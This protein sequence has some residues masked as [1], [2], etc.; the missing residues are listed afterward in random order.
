MSK[1][2]KSRKIQLKNTDEN[3]GVGISHNL[4]K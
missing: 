2:G 1:K 3:S 4:Y